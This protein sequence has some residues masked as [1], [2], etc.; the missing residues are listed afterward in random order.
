MSEQ[1]QLEKELA[2][3][4]RMQAERF[5]LERRELEEAARLYLAAKKDNKTFS[6]SEFGFE[7]SAA[8]IERYIESRPLS[9]AAIEGFRR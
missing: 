1:H 7:F 8:D 5:D 9:R 6:P 2:E 3:L 4:K